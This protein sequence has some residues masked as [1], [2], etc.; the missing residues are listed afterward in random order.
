MQGILSGKWKDQVEYLRTLDEKTYKQEKLKLPACT[1]SGTFSDRVDNGISQYSKYVVIDVDNLTPEVAEGFKAQL[2]ADEYVLYSFLSP[3]GKGIKIVVMVSTD[4]DNHRAAFLHLQNYFETKYGFQVDPSGKNISRLCFVSY[5]PRPVIKPSKVFEVDM[6][7]SVVNN[8]YV[9]NPNLKNFKELR[10]SIAIFNLCKV[11][12][13]KTNTYV[14]GQRNHYIFALACAM[15]RCGVNIHE[16]EEFF[17]QEFSDLDHKEIHTTIKSAY[18]RHQHEFASVEVKDLNTSKFIAPP[19]VANYTDDVVINDV[20][21]V[22]ATLFNYKVPTTEITDIVSKVAKYYHREG[23]L[24][25]DRVNL[26]DLMNKAVLILRENMASI[27]DKIALKYESVE[28]MAKSLIKDKS[29]DFLVPTFIPSIDNSLGGGLSLGNFYGCIG[30]GGT[31]KSILLQFWAC[32]CAVNGIPFLYLNGEMSKVQFYQR[33]C[34][35]VFGIPWTT[36]VRERNLN[37]DN[38]DEFIE[39]VNKGLGNNLHVVNGT[40]YNKENICATI[41]NIEAKTGKKIRMIGVDGLTQ[42]DSLGKE[43]IPAAIH[44]TGVL[45]EISKETN[46]AIVALIHLSGE[47]D[48]TL[49]DTGLR[50]RGGTKMLANMDGYFSTSLLVDKDFMESLDATEELKFIEGMMYLKY[51]DK[52]TGAGVTNCI[53]NIT[54]KLDLKEDLDNP[55]HSYEYK[56]KRN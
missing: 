36:L 9:P 22:T 30:L 40:D 12:V 27:T 24:D 17:N 46:T 43:E 13:N 25:I 55:P 6:K 42:M 37:E 14:T 21:R 29:S 47:N 18:F 54:K 48:K 33:L 45:K 3:S 28:E 31:F 8:T 5:D 39:S 41:T 20:M 26:K 2:S 35:M 15:N 38:I 19:Y 50:V 1:W 11:W 7:Y 34:T 4:A 32:A 52:R 53:I 23:Y 10:D 56:K 49:R 16:T 51:T 44:N